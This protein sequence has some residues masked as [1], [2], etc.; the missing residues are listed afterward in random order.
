LGRPSRV[1]ALAEDGLMRLRAVEAGNADGSRRTPSEPDRR[2]VHSDASVKND[3]KRRLP[4]IRPSC[5]DRRARSG[6]KPAVA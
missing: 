6:V 2:I 4:A 1:A 3:G 5:T